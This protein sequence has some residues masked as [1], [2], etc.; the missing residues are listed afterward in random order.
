[1]DADQLVGFDLGYQGFQESLRV[2]LG[3]EKVADVAQLPTQFA[4]PFH[5]VHGDA[6]PGQVQGSGHAGYPPADDQDPLLNRL[7]RFGG[8]GFQASHL[9]QPGHGHGHQALS[10]GRGCTGVSVDVGTLFAQVGSLHEAGVESGPEHQLLEPGGVKARR[11]AGD[12]HPVELAIGDGF[13]YGSQPVGATGAL[14]HLSQGH[15]PQS[16]GLSGHLGRVDQAVEST[17]AMTDEHPHAGL[18]IGYIA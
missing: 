17:V 12:H 9:D 7:S 6:L 14:H 16:L 13:L 3:V 11:A 1:M 4:F 18:L 8:Q 15:A 5:Q 10:L 2:S